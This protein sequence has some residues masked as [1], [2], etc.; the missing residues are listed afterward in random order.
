MASR[1]ESYEAGHYLHT[2][3]RQAKWDYYDACLFSTNPAHLWS[4]FKATKGR[5]LT[6]IPAIC[7]ADGSTTLDHAHMTQAFCSHFHT[8]EHPEVQVEQVNDFPTLPTRDHPLITAEEVSQALRSTS[9]SSAPGPSGIGYKF[10]KWA[11]AANL[12]QFVSLYNACL[13]TGH[14]HYHS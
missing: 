5:H 3:A 4:A 14:H 7:G 12:D 13:S 1:E 9:N 2:V 11:F 10:I 6:H 8:S